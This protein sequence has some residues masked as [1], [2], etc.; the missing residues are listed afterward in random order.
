MKAFL[1]DDF[2]T[3]KAGTSYLDPDLF[4]GKKDG[5]YIIDDTVVYM[6][7]EVINGVGGMSIPLPRNSIVKEYERIGERD[8]DLLQIQLSELNDKMQTTEDI[9]ISQMGVIKEMLGNADKGSSAVDLAGLTKLIAV[10]QKPDLL[11]GK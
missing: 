8:I 10:A 11:K 9:M 7:V 3:I 4:K 6:L 5:I 2:I 1:V